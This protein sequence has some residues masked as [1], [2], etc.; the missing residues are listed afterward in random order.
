MTDKQVK[1]FF[2]PNYHWRCKCGLI[3]GNEYSC[4]ICEEYKK[5]VERIKAVR[6]MKKTKKRTKTQNEIQ[7]SV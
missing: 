5:R 3:I 2:N 1:L 4:P 7:K 6:K